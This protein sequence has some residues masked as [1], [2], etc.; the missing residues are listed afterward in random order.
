MILNMRNWSTDLKELKK[1]KK[2]YTIWRLEQLVNFG[3]GKE[4]LSRKQLVDNWSVL[5]LDPKKKKY[6][7]LLLWGQ[8]VS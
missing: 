8:R 4:K 5:H 7:K 6:L 3:L 1:D 2:Q